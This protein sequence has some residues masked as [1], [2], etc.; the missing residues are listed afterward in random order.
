MTCLT[1]QS[2]ATIAKFLDGIVNVEIAISTSPKSNTQF[3][4]GLVNFKSSNKSLSPVSQ[5][6]D[7]VSILCLPLAC[8]FASSAV[9]N[10]D[11]GL[12]N[13]LYNGQKKQTVK[14][15]TK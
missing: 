10:L 4:F 9:Q 3:K 13:A 15:Q 6:Q 1:V 11:S 12:K 2:D 14:N 8:T 5:L 7:V